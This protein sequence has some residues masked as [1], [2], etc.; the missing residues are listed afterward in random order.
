MIMSL[1]INYQLAATQT[2]SI[3][4]KNDFKKWIST[5]A[6]IL[7]IPKDIEITIRIVT[8]KEIQLLNKTYRKKD[9]PTNVLSF[10]Y[11]DDDKEIGDIII[12]AETVEKES[13]KQHIHHSKHWAHMAIHGFL[14]LLGYDHQNELSAHKMEQKEA[15]ILKT[16][17]YKNE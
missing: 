4:T 15:E 2:G 8:A 5:A 16:L 10:P 11:S 6:D 7:H 3:P 1:K 13:I 12:C 9:K 14:H 17:N